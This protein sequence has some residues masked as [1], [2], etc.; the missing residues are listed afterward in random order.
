MTLECV[1]DAVACVVTGP[2]QFLLKNVHNSLSINYYRAIGSQQ[3]L[4]FAFLPILI[5]LYLARWHCGHDAWEDCNENGT[6]CARVSSVMSRCDEAMKL[7]V[8]L[9]GASDHEHCLKL[10]YQGS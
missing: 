1:N 4:T 3:R 9:A 7:S 8:P 5:D 2:R 6:S 10:Q